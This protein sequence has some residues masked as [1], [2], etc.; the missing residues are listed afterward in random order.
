MQTLSTKIGSEDVAILEK[1]YSDTPI[2]K[3]TDPEILTKAAECILRIHVITGWNL[4]DDKAYIQVLTEEFVLKLKEDF[5]M[6]NFSEITFAIRRASGKKDWGKNMNL[7]LISTVL[8]EYCHERERLSSEEERFLPPPE[9]KILTSDQLDDLTRKDIQLAFK[10]MKNGRI[11]IIT[12]ESFI[13]VLTKDNLLKE[14]EN[15]SDFFVRALGSG[16]EDIYVKD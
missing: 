16:Q 6:L 5:Y 12:E 1:K 2:S 13:E 8:G 14:G 11:P 4:P 9:Q 3:M 10:C 7:E 15:I